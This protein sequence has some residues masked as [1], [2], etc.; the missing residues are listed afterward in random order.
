MKDQLKVI[1]IHQLNECKIEPM[2]YIEL[3][4]YIDRV[5]DNHFN[6][7]VWKT[8]NTKIEKPIA[9]AVSKMSTKQKALAIGGALAV[10]AGARMLSKRRPNVRPANEQSIAG[11]VQSRYPRA[12]TNI[13]SK[14]DSLEQAR[15]A[16]PRLTNKIYK[17][18]ARLKSIQNKYRVKNQVWMIKANSKVKR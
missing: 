5:S 4:K 10:S 18:I 3:N 14:I 13:Q 8:L 17:K 7:G 6:E 11:A 2:E 15:M 12:I 9:D 16:N 1:L